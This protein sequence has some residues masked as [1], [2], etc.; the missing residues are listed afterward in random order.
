MNR[1]MMVGKTAYT[2]YEPTDQEFLA[3][4]KVNHYWHVCFVINELVNRHDVGKLDRFPTMAEV[5]SAA[6][7]L[8]ALEDNDVEWHLLLEEAVDLMMSGEFE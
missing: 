1:T 3:A 4:M 7:E 6:D 8:E 2:F 5:D